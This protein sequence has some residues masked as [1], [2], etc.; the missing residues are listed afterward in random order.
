MANTTNQST[1]IKNSTPIPVKEYA[2]T[3]ADLKKQIEEAHIKAALA[4][5]K[6]LIKLYWNIGKTIAD[7]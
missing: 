4:A 1:K 2:Q 3:L 6:E 7:K 5:N